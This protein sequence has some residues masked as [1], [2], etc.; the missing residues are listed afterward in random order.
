MLIG[1][2]ILIL[3]DFILDLSNRETT[4]FRYNTKIQ[5][6]MKP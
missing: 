3:E 4:I 6:S 2:D 1:N 5:I